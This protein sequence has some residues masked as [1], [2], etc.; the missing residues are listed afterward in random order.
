MW[1]F[2]R[3]GLKGSLQG[4]NCIL[5]F[6]GHRDDAA[7]SWHLEDVVAVVSHGHELGQRRVPEDGVVRQADVGDVK[8]DELG[9]VVVAGHEG[10]WEADLPDRDC[11]T[12][13]DSGE[14]LGWLKLVIGH[15]EAVECF[16]GQDIEP[17]PFV[18]EGPGDQNVADDWGTKHWKDS[19]CGCALELVC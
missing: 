6:T 4:T 19:S 17:C 2:Q 16:H 12:V 8:V 9:A 5:L 7:T 1:V 3:R 14:G 10:G 18:D 11:G 15:L 13:G